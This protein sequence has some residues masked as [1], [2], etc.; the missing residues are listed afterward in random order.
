MTAG[1]LGSP[2]SFV[3]EYEPPHILDLGQSHV[4]RST[5]ARKHR[6]CFFHTFF[7]CRFRHGTDMPKANTRSLPHVYFPPAS[8]R[9]E[10]LGTDPHLSVL[11]FLTYLHA[12]CPPLKVRKKLAS[13]R[14]C[15]ASS[16]PG[17]SAFRGVS[18][19][20]SGRAVGEL[21][22]PSFTSESFQLYPANPEGSSRRSA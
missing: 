22:W 6:P 12:P 13:G 9:G 5:G 16:M 8:L 20:G 17:I 15:W 7:L 4:D 3:Y 21:C 2:T 11:T 19:L 1:V 14:S 18:S 10:R